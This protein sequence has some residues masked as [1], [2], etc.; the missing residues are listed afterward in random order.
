MYHKDSL[1]YHKTNSSLKTMSTSNTY[2]PQSTVYK[3]YTCLYMDNLENKP[4]S[5]QAAKEKQKAATN[6]KMGTT[7]EPKSA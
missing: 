7:H 3:D 6:A 2:K 5:D 1:Q 4:R